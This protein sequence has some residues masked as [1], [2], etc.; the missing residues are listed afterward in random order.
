MSKVPKILYTSSDSEGDRSSSAESEDLRSQEETVYSRFGG[1][2]NDAKK[3]PKKDYRSD[4][5]ESKASFGEAREKRLGG[6]ENDLQKSPPRD[7]SRPSE[8]ET[9]Y[10]R[11]GASLPRSV[12]ND[13]QKAPKKDYRVDT[14]EV[15]HSFRRQASFG[16]VREERFGG[17][18][19]ESRSRENVRKPFT[20]DCLMG[21]SRSRSFERPPPFSRFGGLREDRF[22][23][24]DQK[25]PSNDFDSENPRNFQ[26]TEADDRVVKN[27]VKKAW[28]EIAPKY[29]RFDSF[30]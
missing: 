24:N 9:V 28:R 7:Y 23:F 11:F 26:A 8:R 16:E 10:S 19:H 27:V 25:K 15:R 22:S 20:K 5:E 14:E 13:L 29:I 30:A 21:A 1:P 6:P 4:T 2:G 3:S 18:G 17:F 12:H